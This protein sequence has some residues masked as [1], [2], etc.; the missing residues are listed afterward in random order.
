MVSLHDEAIS[1]YT[2]NTKTFLML[3]CSIGFVAIGIWILRIPKTV[4]YESIFANIIGLSSIVFFGLCGLC[5]ASILFDRQPRLILDSTGIIDRSSTVSS[6]RILWS[7]IKSIDV[8]Q[9]QD[10]RFLTFYVTNPQR[11]L[12]RGG[13]LKRQMKALN[14]K[15]YGSPVHITS[16][17]LKISFGELTDLIFQY[18]DRYALDSQN[19]V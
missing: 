1:I 19:R 3:L 16:N 7:D 2:S 5:F 6:G 17:S 12:Q 11:Y 9:V 8:T 10:Q 13:F 18:Y 15:Y 14:Y 4:I